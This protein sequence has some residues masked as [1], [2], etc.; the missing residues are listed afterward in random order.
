MLVRCKECRRFFR[1]F[2][3]S[4]QACSTCDRMPVHAEPNPANDLVP[5]EHV[6]TL[7]TED[8]PDARSDI[9]EPEWRTCTEKNCGVSF[10]MER[11]PGRPP[12]KCPKHRAKAA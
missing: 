8:R 4:Q 1:Q 10:R 9:E 3:A 12:R 11:K 6:G 7:R 5:L 2:V